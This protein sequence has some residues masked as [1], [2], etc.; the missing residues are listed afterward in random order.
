MKVIFNLVLFVVLILIVVDIFEFN[1]EVGFVL[2][3]LFIVEFIKFSNLVDILLI[4]LF[5]WINFIF[6]KFSFFFRSFEYE[7]VIIKVKFGGIFFEGYG[8]NFKLFN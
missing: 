4:I 7:G 1:D 3:I 2:I 6:F 5:V 8:L